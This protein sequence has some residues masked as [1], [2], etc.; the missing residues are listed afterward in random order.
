MNETHTYPDGSQRVGC[1]PFPELSPLQEAALA[2]RGAPDGAVLD[3][4]QL[5]AKP[6][7]QSFGGITA[8]PKVQPGRKPK[9]E[10]E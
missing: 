3:H 8:T 9:A 7:R 6:L 1:A 5:V 2:K 4:L 10:A